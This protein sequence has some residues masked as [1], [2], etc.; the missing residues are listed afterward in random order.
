MSISKHLD[1][2]RSSEDFKIELFH[3]IENFDV[4]AQ[5]LGICKSTLYACAEIEKR[6]NHIP[7]YT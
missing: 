1:L 4:K 7:A 6:D 5:R 2:S 3:N